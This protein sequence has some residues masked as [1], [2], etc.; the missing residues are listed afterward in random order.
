LDPSDMSGGANTGLSKGRRA[1]ANTQGNAYISGLG[2][3]DHRGQEK[4]NIE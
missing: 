4:C 3:P 2:G 1:E